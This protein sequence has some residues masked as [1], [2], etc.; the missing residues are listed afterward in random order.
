MTFA[1]KLLPP[2]ELGEKGMKKIKNG[3]L[4]VMLCA[5]SVAYSQV[6]VTPPKVTVTAPAVAAPSA[7]TAPAAPFA[8]EAPAVPTAPSAP[9]APEAPAVAVPTA[10][11]IEAPVPAEPAAPAAI[12]SAAA[13]VVPPVPE[14]EKKAEPVPVPVPVPTPPVAKSEPLNLKFHLGLRAGLGVS[15]LRNHVELGVKK[16]LG[17]DNWIVVPVELRSAFSL[18]MGVAFAIELNSLLTVAPELQYTLYRANGA[19]R[20]GNVGVPYQEEAGVWLHSFELPILARFNFG[21]SLG[22]LYVEVGPQIGYNAEATSYKNDDIRKVQVNKF[23][24]G[25]SLGF[26]TNISETLIGVRC[27]FGL[28][29]YAENTKGYPWTVQISVTKFFF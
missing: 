24:F 23:A 12:D 28:L 7:P 18:G 8:P 10:P 5:A 20:L 25:P 17:K 9:A 1:T 26:G 2:Y 22:A 11:E 6:K 3:L 14:P 15:A 27:Y 19:T 16:E 4:L 13:A 21:S 29:E